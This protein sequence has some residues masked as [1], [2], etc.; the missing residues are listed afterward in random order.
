[1]HPLEIERLKE[2][3]NKQKAKNDDDHEFPP[4]VTAARRSTFKQVMQLVA[5]I[6]QHL[7]GRKIHIYDLDL[8]KDQKKQV[9]YL[10]NETIKIYM[11]IIYCKTIDTYSSI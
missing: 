6:Q 3:V 8:L 9:S 2:L 4:F 1:M 7:P 11:L 10:T 5:S